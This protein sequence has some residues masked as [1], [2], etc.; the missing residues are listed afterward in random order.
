MDNIWT[1]EDN[2]ALKTDSVDMKPFKPTGRFF[3]DV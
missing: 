3:E 2:Q 1:Y